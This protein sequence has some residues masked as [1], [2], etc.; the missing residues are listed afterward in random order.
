[1]KRV[2]SPVF[3]I[4][5]GRSG[6]NML[7]DQLCKLDGFVTWPCDEIDLVFRH[8]NRSKAND[9]FGKSDLNLKAEKYIHST[10][11]NL[12]KKHPGKI[13]VEKTCAN[14]LRIPFL[15][16]L[17]PNAKFV[18]I[19]R[20]GYDVAASARIRWKASVEF[21]YLLKKARFVPKSDI[22]FYGLRFLQNRLH[23]IFSKE[24]NLKKWGPV[25]PRLFEDLRKKSLIE[26]CAHQWA[27]CVE[28]SL[29]DV[30]ELEE[31]RFLILDYEDYVK[32]P[33]TELN[34]IL[35]FL[36]Y[37]QEVDFRELERN[38]YT[39]GVGKYKSQLTENEIQTISKIIDPVLRSTS[40]STLE[41]SL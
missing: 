17:F 4:G 32:S 3:I 25:Y 1:M 38:I 16:A 40:K 26:V 23:S 15:N 7:R 31:G 2:E 30:N 37:R 6:T 22:P 27:A 21:K 5:A 12:Q 34:K 41:K 13:V 39:K 11:S 33:N 18:L 10:F 9:V 14:S 19:K 28:T 20:N 24:K 29:N 35:K 36:N 8:G